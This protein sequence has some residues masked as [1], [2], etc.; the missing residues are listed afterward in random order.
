MPSRTN[1]WMSL[2]DWRAPDMVLAA[3]RGGVMAPYRLSQFRATY[4]RVNS[5]FEVRIFEPATVPVP[6]GPSTCPPATGHSSSASDTSPVLVQPSGT[7]LYSDMP[8]F[9]RSPLPILVLAVAAVLSAAAAGHK[10]KKGGAEEDKRKPKLALRADPSFGFPPVNV[11]LTGHLTGVDLHDRNFCHAS[12]T[13]VR[14]D[15][16]QSERDSFKVRED[17]ACLHPDEETSVTNTFSRTFELYTPGSY[18]I[19]LEIQAKDGTRV[20]SAYSRVE[21]LRLH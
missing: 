1:R 21:V 4:H 8:L 5:P 7:A 2:G 20:V 6:G 17:P 16:G 14:V 3:F 11:T 15:P 18:L 10:E 9:A 12:V 19:R 13:W